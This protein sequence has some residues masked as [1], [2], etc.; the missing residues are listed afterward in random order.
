MSDSWKSASILR[1]Y[2]IFAMVAGRTF[3][4][5][6]K[7]QSFGSRREWV[8]CGHFWG[9]ASGSLF[10]WERCLMRI[11]L[12]LKTYVTSHHNKLLK[13]VIIAGYVFEGC[14]KR[15]QRG[16]KIYLT[17]HHNKLIRKI[18][19]ATRRCNTSNR[20]VR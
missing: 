11:K 13:K 16:L 8:E 9:M 18:K 10:D 20:R 15:I 2:V 1:F 12:G 4:S 6:V 17:S 14:L 5:L 19:M 7:S 3:V